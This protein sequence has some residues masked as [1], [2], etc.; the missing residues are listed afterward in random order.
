MG[1]IFVSILGLAYFV[2]AGLFVISLWINNTTVHISLCRSKILGVS[3]AVCNR[4]LLHSKNIL[5]DFVVFYSFFQTKSKQSPYELNCKW[6][7]ILAV[8]VTISFCCQLLSPWVMAFYDKSETVPSTTTAVPHFTW[9]VFYATFVII[10]CKSLLFGPI[11]K[12]TILTNVRIKHIL[13]YFITVRKCLNEKKR[14]VGSQLKVVIDNINCGHPILHL[15]Y[16][17]MINQGIRSD[18]KIPEKV[19]FPD[20]FECMQFWI[21]GLSFGRLIN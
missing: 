11:F 4:N 10:G 1:I 2:I 8:L 15:F 21:F 13:S 14:L 9:P 12:N 3:I 18:P 6:T 17:I 19:N 16:A 5:I 7:L 20:S